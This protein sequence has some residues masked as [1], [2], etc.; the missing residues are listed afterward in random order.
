VRRPRDFREA[1][2]TRSEHMQAE[3]YSHGGAGEVTGSKHFLRV[4]DTTLMVDCGAFQGRREESELKNRQWP[5]KATD[6]SAAILT[7]AH[8]DHC[9]LMP[10]MPKNGFTGNIYATPASRDLASL[11][12]MDSAHIMAKD[13]EFLKKRAKK[14][15]IAFDKQPLYGE[16]E[17][18]KVLDQFMTVSYHRR[19]PVADGINATFFDAGH[20][21]G[22]A[23]TLVEATHNNQK[24]KV[25]F[26]GDLGRNGLPILRDPEQIPP[27]NYL[28][29]ESTYGNRLHDP[30]TKA[31]DDLAKVVND[32][33]NRGGKLII[34]A[35]AVERMQELI[36]HLNLLM[37]DQKIPRVPVYVDSPMASNATAIFQVHQECY[38]DE[39]RTEFLDKHQN[40][41][42]FDDLKYVS[43]IAES[44]SLNDLKRPAIILAS[45]GMCEAGRILHHLL[46]NVEDPKNT[47][48][49][50]GFMAENTLGRK[51]LERQPQLSIL[52]ESRKLLAQTKV[53]NAFSAHADYNDI[54]AY[55]GRLDRSQL[56]QV[57][58]VHGETE[59]QA[60]LKRLLDERQTKT[61]IVK[62]GEHYQLTGD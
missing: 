52:G 11:V 5:F 19:F 53:L 26:T 36:Y 2:W 34:P 48:L 1:T 8:F 50:V 17:V 58:L 18:V 3:L 15:G 32:T 29:I 56:R 12:M 14:K 35:F 45:S 46:N 25:G 22:S 40:P 27:V 43:S 60:N 6:V 9:G 44:K 39:T 41:F 57:F 30:V 42:G 37:G 54:L 28:V 55:V 49:I 13:L 51:I 47:I 38:D 62:P 33:I 10:L 4:K 20:I 24:I 31:A 16:N 59:A 61:T 7:H 21:L 23:I